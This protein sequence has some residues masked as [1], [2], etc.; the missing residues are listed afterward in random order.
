MRTLTEEQFKKLYGEQ[1]ITAFATP[2]KKT[3]GQDLVG[4]ISQTGGAIRDIFSETS[5]RIGEARQAELEGRQSGLR[6][7]AQSIGLTAGATARGVGELFKGGVKA[8]LPEETEEAIRGGISSV[9]EPVGRVALS[10]PPV[11]KFLEDYQNLSEEQKR[12]VDALFGVGSGAFELATAGFGGRVAGAGKKIAQEGLEGAIDIT[13]RGVAPVVSAVK[14]ATELATDITEGVISG[15]RNIP[16]KV[17]TNIAEKQAGIQ[18]IKSL[19]TKTA[20]ETVKMGVDIADVNTLLRATKTQKPAVK[21]LIETVKSFASGKSNV[22]PDEVVG[23]PMVQALKRLETKRSVVGKKLGE[24]ADTL[25]DVTSDEV[26]IPVLQRLREVSGLE[27]LKSSNGI[28]DFSDTVLGSTLTSADQKAIQDVFLEAIQA[29]TGKQKHLL[30]QTIFET[31]GGKKKALVN[32]TDTQERAY[33]AIRKGLADILDT[34][35][36]TYKALNM[37]Y[38][39]LSEPLKK[40]RKNLQGQ[41]VLDEDLLEM[42]A[43][44]LARRLTSNAKSNPELRQILRNIDNILKEGTKKGETLL[45]LENLQDV[46]NVLDKY[47]DIAPKTGFKGQIKSAISSPTISGKI[48]EAI[49]AVAEL[50][51]ETPA[52]RQ[53]AIEKLLEEL[54]R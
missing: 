35:N 23:K 36:P 46:Y 42:S 51:G 28:L 22:R 47:Y 1:A 21:K 31:L 4:D 44:N 3:F 14:P 27:G 24:I 49:G 54:L 6:G 20:Q 12:D 18:A 48:N 33:E 8:V 37:E 38:A 40:L 17:A 7:M 39:K 29:G 26:S 16:T 52:V 10:L 45:N 50:A 53:K 41:G 43:G 13:K 2:T 15:V 11:R 30:R 19:P 25:G 9:A 5:Q 32:I 34:K